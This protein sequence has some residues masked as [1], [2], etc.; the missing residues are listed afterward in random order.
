MKG[1]AAHFR[2]ERHKTQT[3]RIHQHTNVK[4]HLAAN[5]HIV[6]GRHIVT[7][8]RI[9]G[10]NDGPVFQVEFQGAIGGVKSL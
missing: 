8:E 7:S 5:D 6:K 1:C 9:D 4:K 10:D 3:T 2:K